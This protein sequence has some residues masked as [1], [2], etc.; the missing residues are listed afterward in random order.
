M[1]T[2]PLDTTCQSTIFLST[3]SQLSISQK[4]VETFPEE[5]KCTVQEA[6]S[7]VKISSGSIAWRDLIP[8]LKG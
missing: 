1:C 7:Q 6:E 8:A 3:A 2:T 4:A 5:M